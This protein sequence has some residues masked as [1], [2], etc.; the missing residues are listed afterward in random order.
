MVDCGILCLRWLPYWCARRRE[1]RNAADSGRAVRTNFDSDLLGRRLG[2]A[3]R[4]SWEF[5]AMR[6]LIM[7]ARRREECGS[8]R[9]AEIIGIRYL[10]AS[11][12]R[13]LARWRSRLRIQIRFGRE[14]AKVGRFGIAM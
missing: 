13:R 9:T 3:F 8:P 12:W 10:T 2:I 11:R 1:M 6:A 7:R 5:P 4:R 14:R